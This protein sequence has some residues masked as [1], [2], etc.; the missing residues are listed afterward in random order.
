MEQ[1]NTQYNYLKYVK[2]D[3]TWT[4]GKLSSI[5]ALRHQKVLI[6]EQQV[7]DT[8]PLF[9]LAQVPHAV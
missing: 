5:Q 6:E 8:N 2:K 4:V 1:K 3:R 9:R 7:G